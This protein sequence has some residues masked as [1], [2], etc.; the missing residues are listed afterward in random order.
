M[1]ASRRGFLKKGVGLAGAIA[2]AT[3]LAVAQETE[4]AKPEEKPEAKMMV[5]ACGMSCSACP[6]MEAK[7]CKGCAP[8]TKASAKMVEMK[9][10]PVL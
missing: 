1:D 9:K 3:G 4:A 5:G 8:G 6:L 2:A 7:K 10:C